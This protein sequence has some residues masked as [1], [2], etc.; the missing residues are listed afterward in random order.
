MTFAHFENNRLLKGWT[1][2]LYLMDD[3]SYISIPHASNGHEAHVE[4]S[5]SESGCMKSTWMWQ[6]LHCLAYST[7][8]VIMLTTNSLVI[9]VGL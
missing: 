6:A 1:D 4:W 7:A 5:S 3:A 2:D 8:S 9:A